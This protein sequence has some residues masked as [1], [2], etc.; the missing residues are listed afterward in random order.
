MGT[1]PMCLIHD[2]ERAR[3]AHD[4]DRLGCYEQTPTLG[5]RTHE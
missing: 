4:L 1:A 3:V 5:T 2:N